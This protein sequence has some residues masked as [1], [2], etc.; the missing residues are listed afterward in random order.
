MPR[1]SNGGTGGG[2][3]FASIEMLQSGGQIDNS[4]KYTVSR[5]YYVTKEADLITT[6]GS[7]SVGGKTMLPSALSY[8]K[9][10]GGVWEKTIEFTAPVKA[11]DT[12]VVKALSTSDSKQYEGRLQMD[13]SAVPAPIE[14]HPEINDLI[15][16]Y[17]GTTQ[18]GKVIFPEKY[19]EKGTTGTSTGPLKTNPFFGV[20]YYYQPAA[21][22]RHTYTLEKMPQNIWAGVF[23]IVKTEQLPGGFPSLDDY[24]NKEGATLKYYWQIQMPQI[25]LV[26]GRIE[27]TDTYTLLKPMPETAAADFNKIA[28]G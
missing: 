21:T 15:K 23:C 16:K 20:R 27:I 4:G 5:K 1:G 10:T 7:I 14:Q 2:A 19:R 25:A 12:G 13:V 8:Q 11:T 3:T 9:I 24:L 28:A 18:K 26:G 6:P 17:N 22:L